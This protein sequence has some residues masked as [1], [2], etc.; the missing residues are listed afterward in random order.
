VGA[1][2]GA[3]RAHDVTKLGRV[4]RSSSV[5]SGWWGRGERGGGAYTRRSNLPGLSKAE[6]SRSGGWGRGFRIWRQNLD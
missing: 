5:N 2:S 4:R 6:S 1:V 3:I